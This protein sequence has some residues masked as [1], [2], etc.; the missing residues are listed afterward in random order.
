MNVNIFLAFIAGVISFLS[1]CIFPVIPSYLSYI[2]GLS[3]SDLTGENKRK[4]NLLLNSILFVAGFTLIFI[5]MG[6]FFS[7]IG[8]ALSGIASYIN[9]A[10]GVIV[11]FLGLNFILNFWKI[12]NLEKRF[13]FKN[14]PAGKTGSLLL[15]MAFGAGWTPCIGPILA[16]ILIIAGTSGSVYKGAVLLFVFSAGLGIPFIV[17]GLFFSYFQ[18]TFIK[19]RSHLNQ[20]KIGSGLF[21]I[22]MG[23]LIFSGQLTRL[24]I[25]LY[26]LA[27]NIRNWEQDHIQGVRAVYGSIFLIPALF[28]IVPIRK[29]F[30][31]LKGKVKNF[32]NFP[33]L[34]FILFM[35]LILLSG[36]AYTG[37]IDIGKLLQNWLTFQGI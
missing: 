23:I 20:I 18:K 3:I 25:I 26:T 8:V 29:R 14:R 15:G 10:A 19:I 9:M 6:V 17:A 11:I 27:G 12:L 7:S 33:F 13:H 21:L 1:P 22:V 16:S 2:G 30:V 34:Y 35:L 31:S 32:T 24:N 4:W 28:T 5:V 36:L 37:L